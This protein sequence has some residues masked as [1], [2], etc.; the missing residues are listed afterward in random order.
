MGANLL[1]EGHRILGKDEGN[2][3][4]EKVK[5]VCAVL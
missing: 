3:K 4:R 2:E 5:K 1:N